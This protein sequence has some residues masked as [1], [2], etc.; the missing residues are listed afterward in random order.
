MNRREGIDRLEELFHQAL[1]LEPEARARFIAGVRDLDAGLG[2]EVES[3][4]AA[5]EEGSNLLDTP[6]GLSADAQAAHLAGSS[7]A[8]YQVLEL[9]GKG[10]MGEVWRARDT[11]LNRDVALKVLPEAF[12]NSADRLARF[13]REAQV[14]ASLNHPNIAVIYDLVESEG[15]QVLVMEMV[16]GETLAD[17]LKTGALPLPESLSIALQI[18]EALRAAH[19]KGIIHRDLKPANIKIKPEGQ[20]K[21]LDFGLA[22]QFHGAGSDTD[23]QA[24]TLKESMT[25][26][27]AII[28]TPAY[29]S[30]EQAVGEAA[31]PRSDIFSFGAVLY[32]MLTGRRAFS[33]KTVTALFHA[34]LTST[35]ASPKRL[36][37]EVPVE[38]D[39]LVNRAL[40][41]E[42]H[43]RQ[44]NCEQLCLEL[45]LINTNISE[46][47][48]LLKNRRAALVAS[49]L[50]LLLILGAIGWQVLRWR[51]A[52]NTGT[53]AGAI[54]VNPAASSYEL[55]QQG[56][57]YLERWDIEKNIDAALQAFNIALSKDQNYAPAYAGLGMA[58]LAKFQN[59]RDRS[60]LDLAVQNAQQAVKLDSHMAIS[61]VSLGRA[62]AERG[63][64]SLARSELDEA[65]ILDPLNAGA[66][67]GLAD[68]EQAGSNWA[69]AERLYKKALDLSPDN[70]D[71]HFILGNFYYRLA[72]YSEAEQAYNRVI[73][74]APDSHLGYRNLGGVYHMQGRFADASA[75]YQ[76]ALQIR[77]SASTYSNLGTSLFFQGLYQQSV[78]AFEK[79]IE[80]GAS[81]YQIWANLGDAYRQTPGNEEKA[82]EAFQTAI[83][84][85]RDELSGKPD[86]GDLRSQLALYLAKSGEKQEALDHAA[87]ARKL[88][89]SAPVV[90]TL[91]LI[92]E[93]CGLREQALE[94]MG[95]A[96]KSGYSLEEFSRDPELFELR[97]DP[98]YHKLV[99][100]LSNTAQK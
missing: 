68:I 73:N 93:I 20:V 98:R 53:P 77:A 18:A 32:E 97:K 24:A 88:D 11:R 74:L 72:R 83:R 87:R 81:N 78:A 100:K 17:K 64:S 38:L 12:A 63:D 61:R 76:N 80:L 58:Y 99:A 35:P 37:P 23:S 1:E 79:A 27:G 95:A 29:M 71:L 19:K 70:W 62:Y 47:P 28:G 51:D 39:A 43:E 60:L 41:K 89:Q 10:G 52:S 85:V 40:N 67:R 7:I 48:S 56:V 91:V 75:Q 13:Q 9:L 82:R 54:R 30:P 36:R 31:D 21:V 65:L 96:L 8:Q 94:A 50:L 5:H 2:A 92:Y 15:E 4:V 55:F 33:G 6:P 42:R 59:N 44:Q 16:E 25:V 84:L 14:L 86:D 45:S 46:K 90:A 69:E 22:K 57:A 49:A 34:I 3:L 66:Y 26:A